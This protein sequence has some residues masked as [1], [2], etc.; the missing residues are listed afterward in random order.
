MGMRTAAGRGR[1][2]RSLAGGAARPSVEDLHNSMFGTKV[3]G[4]RRPT[5]DTGDDFPVLHE[6]PSWP[7]ERVTAPGRRRFGAFVVTVIM[8][9]GLGLLG[10]AAEVRYHLVARW[11][12]K[13]GPQ[14]GRVDPRAESFLADGERALLEGD[15][16]RAQGDL[17]KASVLT[18][19]DPRVLVDEARVTAAKADVP[20]LKLRLLPTDGSASVE[21]R[22]ANAQLEER[23]AIARRAANDAISVA[24][25]DA[26]ALRAVLDAL[27]IAGEGDS[28]RGY[29]VAV[30]ATA[31]QPQTAYALAALDLLQPK[32][33]W[34]TVIDRLRVAAGAEGAAGRARA[35]LVY[36]LAKSGDL[37]GAKAELAKLDASPRPYPL[38][39]ELHA[40][41]AAILPPVGASP[42]ASESPSATPKGTGGPLATGAGGDV[43]RESPQGALESAAE[44]IARHDFGRAEQIYQAILAGN[45]NDSQAVAGLG[46]VARV[47]GDSSGAISAYRRAIA[48]NPSYLPA[49]LG[50]ADTEWAS[51]DHAGAARVYKDIVNRFPEGSYPEYAARRVGGG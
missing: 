22:T 14:A 8:L 7:E 18:E 12:G 41:L 4:V 29:V 34:A 28:A 32:P 26:Q 24:P 43:G 38:Q 27:R 5:A 37:D 46:D 51:G 42:S 49:L 23:A 6:D 31:S 35:A 9:S 13:I 47:R 40:F 48:I 21:V 3:Q 19:R 16:E 1:P 25:N 11:S 17:D 45:P 30:F 39:P 2:G 33:P 20:W 44:A 10:W 15:L 36:T 50:L